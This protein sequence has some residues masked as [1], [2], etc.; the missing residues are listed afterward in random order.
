[1]A[2]NRIDPIS[3]PS[4]TE[5]RGEKRKRS[6][7]YDTLASDPKL[8]EKPE[9]SQAV[10]KKTGNIYQNPIAHWAATQ[11]WPQEF[12]QYSVAMSERTSSKRKS[13]STHRSDRLERLAENGIFMRTSALMQKSSKELCQNLLDHKRAPVRYTSFPRN[14]L[15]N[16]LERVQGLNESRVRRDVTPWV[17]P[18]AETLFFCGDL[19]IDYIGDEVDA[20]WTRCA[21]MGSTRPKP[22]Y[23][24]GLLLSAFTK[25]E[26]QKLKNYASPPRPFLF[27]PDL[28]F[29]FLIC[30]VK[31]GE[32]GLNKA[33][34]QNIHSASIAARAIIE[35]YKAAFGSS[36]PE[37]VSELYG[38]V[39]IFTVSHD[40]DR[41]CLYAHFA[42]LT[43]QN[44]EQP[45]FYRYLIAIFSLTAN[46]GADSSAASDFVR[47][48]YDK[49]APEHRQRI[50]E[51]AAFLPGVGERT[52]L[53]FT[54]SEL[55]LDEMTSQGNSQDI[56]S[57][58][59]SG[60]RTP[61][62]PATV[63]L[64]K[65]N[66]KLTEQMELQRSE[67]L[68]Q[69]DKLL[70]QMSQQ[71]EQMERQMEQQREQMERQMELQRSESH[72]QIGKLLEQMSQQ[73]E[74]MERQMEQQREQMERQMVQQR[75][76]ME[77]QKEQLHQQAEIISLL[78]HERR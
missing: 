30:E 14:K 28:S 63:L 24:A 23:V 17:V 59:D 31:T 61:S 7:S 76:Q 4:Q 75:E 56:Q 74:Q 58:D 5:Y 21:T 69:I 6:R 2:D 39:L 60:F 70:E 64:K 10:P 3:Y 9:V 77:Q 35:L 29:P 18:S 44:A 51:A 19:N 11:F 25:D 65:E 20:E 37:R 68:A 41:V 12:G 8:P 53:S 45:E 32:Q 27:T 52:N 66:Q 22:D 72:A 26:V 57:H 46:D 36:N 15:P 48:L 62:L 42:V 55:A 50:K 33:D 43:S 38:K 34:R 1:M 16:V 67:S 71:R 73:R 40:N 47:N 54:A 78:K 49:F 13:D